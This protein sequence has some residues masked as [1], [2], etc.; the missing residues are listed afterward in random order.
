MGNDNHRLTC[1]VTDT[2][3]SVHSEGVKF[4]KDLG[5][6]LR[7]RDLPGHD[8]TSP[9]LDEPNSDDEASP[10]TATAYPFYSRSMQSV[11][12]AAHVALAEHVFRVI[13]TAQE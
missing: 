1:I 13:R 2:F 7:G 11:S 4:L 3:G 6:R 9:L 12:L 8:P 10:P 5:A